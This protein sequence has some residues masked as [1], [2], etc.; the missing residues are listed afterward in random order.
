MKSLPAEIDVYISH[1][2]PN[3]EGWCTVDKAKALACHVLEHKPS[4]CVE[5]GVF[6]GRSLFAIALALRHNKA[7]H[8]LGID[9][10]SAVAS[11]EGFQE[12]P[13]NRDWWSK[14]DHHYIFR[15]FIRVREHLKLEPWIDF[16]ACTSQQALAM[17]NIVK[18]RY[19]ARFIDLLHIDG[20]HS[21]KQALFDVEHYVPMVSPGG[22]VFFDDTDWT[23]TKL[24][25]NLLAQLCD[26][27]GMVG[28]CG[29]YR[30]K[31]GENVREEKR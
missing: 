6:A 11:I 29:V 27:T 15:E 14:C 30:M 20:N 16:L 23:T 19:C 3:T 5:I 12:D 17:L 10:W 2:L 21:E 9:P 13:P 24:A 31:G 4:I 25:Q 8:A 1:I 22:F 26:Q 18:E 28:N 7:G